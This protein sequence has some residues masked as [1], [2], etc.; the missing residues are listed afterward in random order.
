MASLF[1][2]DQSIGGQPVMRV[3]NI[4]CPNVVLALEHMMDK[5]PAHVVDFIYKIRLQVE[6][7]AMVMHTVNPLVMRLSRTHS[8]EDM[9]LMAFSFERCS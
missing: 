9:D 8:G 4:E 5:G 2:P 7:T 6:R 3:N 1:D